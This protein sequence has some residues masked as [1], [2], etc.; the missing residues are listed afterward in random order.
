[1]GPEGQIRDVRFG[2]KYLYPLG[3]FA[4]QYV[5]FLPAKN[6]DIVKADSF[7]TVTPTKGKEILCEAIK[8]KSLQESQAIIS[9]HH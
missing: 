2:N 3:Y 9:I 5:N 8:W 6:N 4:G 7:W 1:M